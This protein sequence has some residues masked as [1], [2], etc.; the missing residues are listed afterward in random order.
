MVVD[1]STLDVAVAR[2][3]VV[4]VPHTK[5]MKILFVRGRVE[6]HRNI[7]PH[8]VRGKRERERRARSPGIQPIP[9]DISQR[10]FQRSPLLRCV[11]EKCRGANVTAPRPFPLGREERKL[12]LFDSPRIVARHALSPATLF[13]ACVRVNAAGK[14]PRRLPRET[15]K[16]RNFEEGWK[17]LA[18]RK[19]GGRGESWVG[20]VRCVE[21]R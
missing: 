11:E 15:E 9:L 17:I 4:G 13:H 16:I 7:G 3:G 21:S 5:E 12:F 8:R 18:R 2:V 1:R 10:I 19:V 6:F 20:G 14:F